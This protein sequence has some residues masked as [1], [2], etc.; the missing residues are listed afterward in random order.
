MSIMD[1]LM[2]RIGIPTKPKPLK[3]GWVDARI[4]LLPQSAPTNELR[5]V[6]RDGRRILQQQW[7]VVTPHANKTMP[8][9][10]RVTLAERHFEWRDVP[11]VEEPETKEN[12]NDGK[13]RKPV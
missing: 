4:D 11:L 7:I 10:I 6:L 13:V 3:E 2:R 1:A 12:A 8:T 5:F 9:H